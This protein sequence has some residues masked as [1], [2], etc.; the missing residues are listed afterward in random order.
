MKQYLFI[1]GQLNGGGAER[2]LLD[3]LSNFDY[4][5][6]EV[7][8]LQVIGGGTLANEIPSQVKVVK[9]WEGYDLSYKIATRLALNFNNTGCW[10]RRMIKA[11]GDSRYDVAI[12]FLEGLPLKAHS[13]ITDVATR[14]YSWVHVDI[15]TSHY[16]ASMFSDE[17]DELACYNKMDAVVAVAHG[18]ADA[19]RRRFPACASPVK[20]IYNPIDIDKIKRMAIEETISNDCFTIAVVGR[21]SPKRSWIEFCD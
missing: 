10:R 13:L 15:N 6:N 5:K 17:A 19:F 18:T 14:N 7:T 3:I 16:E 11:L 21:F 2:V 4:T 20:V 1:D 8:L 9:A 12:S